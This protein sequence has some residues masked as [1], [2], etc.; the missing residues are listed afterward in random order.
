LLHSL[1]F[2]KLLSYS[3]VDGSLSLVSPSETALETSGAVVAACGSDVLTLFLRLL[4][5]QFF[6]AAL[7]QAGV[8][9]NNRVYNSA[10]VVWLMIFQCLVQGTLESAVL[11]L[12]SGG[13]P[14]SFWPK[15]CKRVAEA[16]R[17]GGGRLSNETSAFNKG[18]QELSS[19]V[20]EQCYDH[21]FQQLIEPADLAPDR[22]QAFF[23]DGTTVRM[24]HSE[25]L[26]KSYPPTGNQHGT[27]HWPSL[28]LLVAHDLYTGLGMRPEWGPVNG[29]KGKAVSE[30]SLLDKAIDRLPSDATVVAD[31]NFGV[32]S[33]AWAAAQSGHPVVL[34]L[35]KVRAMHLAGG[36]LQ[37]GTDRRIRW[38]PTRE[39]RRSHPDLPKDAS[40]SGRLIV[41]QVQ[42]NNGAEPFL[43][44]LFTTLE[45]APEAVAELYGKRWNIEL[46]LRQ[47]KN[48][49][50]LDELT[51]TSTEMVAKEINVRMLTYNLVRATICLTALKAGLEP[52]VFS[53]TQ[54]KNVLQAFLP[55]IAAATDERT[56]RKLYDDMEYYLGRC[57]LPQRQ[58]PSYPRAVWPKPKS[59]PARHA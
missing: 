52:R 17:E 29:G 25:D 31:A 15:P 45:D 40:V 14:S 56:R 51:C 47:L 50:R 12:L 33:V 13:L 38:K 18:R 59:Y 53:F 28:R 7:E 21:A 55:R 5:V 58:R 24:P 11:E 16:A 43:L 8:K 19:P 49:L 48:T 1:D 41:R 42:P 35:T 4:P 23:F 57:K 37:D 22:R 2:S 54:V 34:R 6:A 46:D 39:D 36:P 32:F 30:Q 27:S 3:L 9:E 26:A 44:A 20:L 10:V